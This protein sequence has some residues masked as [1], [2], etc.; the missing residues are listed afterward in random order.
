[1]YLKPLDC[2]IFL[3]KYEHKIIRQVLKADKLINQMRQKHYT[4]SFILI[5][6]GD[7]VLVATLIYLMCGNVSCIKILIRLEKVTK[8]VFAHF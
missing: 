8:P 4:R 1:M 7:P 6:E 2:S 3:L 5:G